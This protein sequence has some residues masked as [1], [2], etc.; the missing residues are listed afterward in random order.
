MVGKGAAWAYGG[1]HRHFCVVHEVSARFGKSG[2]LGS[3]GI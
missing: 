1:I 3:A 2:A